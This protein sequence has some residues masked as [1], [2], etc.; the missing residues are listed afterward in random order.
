MRLGDT[1][2]DVLKLQKRLIELGYLYKDGVTSKF[3][4]LTLCG[5]TGYQLE[6]GLEVDGVCGPAT[7]KS[8]GL[9]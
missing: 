4:R 2:V 8:L 1:G 9:I 6:A 7:Q 5:V 3:D